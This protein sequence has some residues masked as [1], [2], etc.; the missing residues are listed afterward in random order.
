MKGSENI[1]EDYIAENFP[2]LGEETDIQVLET[3]SPK[4]DQHTSRYI[5]INMSKITR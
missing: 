1:F 3:R 2:N 5:V 4:Q